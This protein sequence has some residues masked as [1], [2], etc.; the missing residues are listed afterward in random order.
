M[1]VYL[2]VTG[3]TKPVFEDYLYTYYTSADH[4]G[5]SQ[6]QYSI[7]KLGTV[8]G[9]IIGI[10]AYNLFLKQA[11]IRTVIIISEILFIF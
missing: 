8:L 7:I 11:S 9:M 4:S 1:F 2:I 10:A 3:P 6:L 5:F